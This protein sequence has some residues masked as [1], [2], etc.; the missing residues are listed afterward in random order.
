[1]R[2]NSHKSFHKQFKKLP[3]PR[4][5]RVRQ[6]V[7]LYV[8]HINKPPAELRTHALSGKWQGYYSISVGGDL[9]VHF[10]IQT[11]S[12][13]LIAVGTHAQLYQ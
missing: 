13:T 10:R 12:I 11:D 1:M 4:Q 9:R 5:K 2:I 6:A 7:N 3:N 8:Q